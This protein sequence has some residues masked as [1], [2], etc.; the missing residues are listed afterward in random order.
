M[1]MLAGAR[2]YEHTNKIEHIRFF[3]FAWVAEMVDMVCADVNGLWELEIIVDLLT[4]KVGQVEFEA[5]QM[6]DEI[7]GHLLETGPDFIS[8]LLYQTHMRLTA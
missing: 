6:E 3:W 2:V 5:L 1:T 7:V 8:F 4:A